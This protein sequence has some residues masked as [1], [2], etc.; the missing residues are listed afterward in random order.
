MRN[1]RPLLDGVHGHLSALGAWPTDPLE[2][3]WDG[4]FYLP[5]KQNVQST[6]Q[7]KEK[8]THFVGYT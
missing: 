6:C 7:D 5:L 2:E 4:P 8:K 3:L 1:P